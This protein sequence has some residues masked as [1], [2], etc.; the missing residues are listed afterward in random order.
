MPNTPHKRPSDQPVLEGWLLRESTYIGGAVNKRY[1]MLHSAELITLR[2]A[3]DF[4]TAK[5]W[6]LDARCRVDPPNQKSFNLVKHGR[7][8]TLWAVISND[9]E[10]VQL[11]YVTLHTSHGPATL[12]FEDSGEAQRWFAALRD[13]V[14]AL[15]EAKES[16]HVPHRSHGSFTS[17]LAGLGGS[18]HGG[19]TWGGSTNGSG[20]R[21]GG[22]TPSGG[23]T[24]RASA[25]G[26]LRT[27][28]VRSFTRHAPP[29]AEAGEEPNLIR[30]SM[31][32]A[33]CEKRRKAR[34]KWRPYTY[35]N[36]VSVYLETRKEDGAADDPAIMTSHIIRAPPALCAQG[37]ITGAQGL[38]E[39]DGGESV[40]VLESL[41][42]HTAVVRE[43][44][45][46]PRWLRPF[47]ATRELVLKRSWRRDDDG[48]VVVLY[49]STTH[50]KCRP[51]AAAWWQWFAPVRAS[52]EAGYTFSPLMARYT[53]NGASGECL[54][55]QVVKADLAGWLGNPGRRARSFLWPVVFATSGSFLSRVIRAAVVLREQVEQERF[56]VRPSMLGGGDEAED[57][58]HLTR[59]ASRSATFRIQ[60]ASG[61]L[62]ARRSV[63]TTMAPAD[64]SA[65]LPATKESPAAGAGAGKGDGG[66]QGEQRVPDVQAAP[67][68]DYSVTGTMDQRFWL[69]PGAAGFKVRGGSYLRDHKKAAAGDPVFEL[70][71]MDLV[72]TDA[73][74]FHIARFL[75]SIKHSRAPFTFVVQIMVPQ[76]PPLSLTAAWAADVNPDGAGKAGSTA[77]SEATSPGGDGDSDTEAE[78][79]SPFDIALARFVAGGDDA[80]S[81]EKRNAAFKLIPKIVKGSWLVKQSVGETPVLLGHKLTTK[82]YRG[83]N[84]MEV[85]IDVASSSVA[86][87]VVGL[88][89]GAA[90]S[91]VVDMGILL[92]G[93]AA[94]ELPESLLGTMRL[95]QLD[96]STASYLDVNTGKLHPKER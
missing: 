62:P 33:E 35:V 95:V 61:G 44:W 8:K 53:P 74:C 9:A 6:R 72:E 92:Q 87:H 45:P 40:S 82:Y 75:P 26:T 43:A 41:D 36:G 71:S 73:P 77:G 15:K 29:E 1:A 70:A 27:G 90:K 30:S 68:D 64:A 10:A 81:T 11:K 84:Y 18:A 12:A 13:T 89:A 67:A 46:P 7:E 78:K 52:V 48:T 21:G 22:H 31:S 79:A 47:I 66:E 56:L 49:S 76:S 86:R 58:G 63:F 37:M 16:E 4:S 88:V 34:Q 80:E 38:G 32:A 3:D 60:R 57:P 94:D 28:D 83:P 96:L 91:V 19:S 54:V 69:C 23:V 85:D 24:P 17:H 42:S 50:H 2:R 59:L 14:G 5:A 65:P 25:I 55:T 39:D 51:R 20:H 93:N